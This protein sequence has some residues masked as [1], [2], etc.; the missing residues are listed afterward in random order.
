LTSYDSLVWFTAYKLYDS[1]NWKVY[2]LM[3]FLQ[4]LAYIFFSESVC[5]SYF[6]FHDSHRPILPVELF[7]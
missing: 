2:N 4:C 7:E 3:L 1:E 6:D 5:N